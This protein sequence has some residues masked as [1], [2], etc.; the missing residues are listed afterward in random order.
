M[1]ESRHNEMLGFLTIIL[2]A[3]FLVGGLQITLVTV[4]NPEWF[5]YF[6]YKIT[7]HPQSFLGLTLTILGFLQM[8]TGFSVVLYYSRRRGWFMKNLGESDS[9]FEEKLADLQKTN[10]K[11]E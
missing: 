6:P 11:H 1:Q 3:V 8:T 5:I 10:R 4:S 2:G 9:F 7:P